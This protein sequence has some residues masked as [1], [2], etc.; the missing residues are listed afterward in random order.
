LGTVL[1]RTSL[2]DSGN[3]P[4][5][6]TWIEFEFLQPVPLQPNTQY[7]LRLRS[8]PDSTVV[9]SATQ[10]R[11]HWG[12][13]HTAYVPP[14]Y[15]G[16]IAY[17]FIDYQGSG[18]YQELHQYDFSFRLIGSPCGPPTQT[19]SRHVHFN[20]NAN[21]QDALTL[22]LIFPDYPADNYDIDFQ[23]NLNPDRTEF[24]WEG[25]VL[26]GPTGQKTEQ[27]LKIHTHSLSSSAAQFCIHRDRR[28]NDKA[29]R[30]D[31]DNENLINYS[32][33]GEVTQGTSAYVSEPELQ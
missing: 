18:W 12:Y 29:L 8:Q 31:L 3:L 5:E 33:G 11:I 7:F 27:K 4:T 32:A 15:G 9:Y 21:A 19:D 6:L 17:R 26:V 20:Y 25:T 13:I 23:A 16:G 2:I 14:G 10:P 24:F 28:F 1:G 22:H 30:I